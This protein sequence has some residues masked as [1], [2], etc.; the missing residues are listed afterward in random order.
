MY[1]YL[2][3]YL[4]IILE[5]IEQDTIAKLSLVKIIC[6]RNIFPALTVI[7]QKVQPKLQCGVWNLI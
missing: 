6:I 2:K 3:K 7:H 4:F 5:N 1:S